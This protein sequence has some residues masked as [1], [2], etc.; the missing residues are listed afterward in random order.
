M[1]RP[2]RFGVDASPLGRFFRALGTG[3]GAPLEAWGLRLS[4]IDIDL[5][6]SRRLRDGREHWMLLEAKSFGR[7]LGSAQARMLRQLDG[8]LRFA[9]AAGY[10]GTVYRGIHLVQCSNAEILTSSSLWIDGYPCT[11]DDLLS[12]VRFEAPDFWYDRRPWR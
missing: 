1:T 4:V 2:R 5:Y 3:P 10:G 7:P 9:V 8:A 12:F 6:V 11:L